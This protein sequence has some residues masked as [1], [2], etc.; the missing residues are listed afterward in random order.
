MG[1]LDHEANLMCLGRAVAQTSAP[2]VHSTKESL[3][4]PCSVS[5]L[6]ITSK[7]PSCQEQI[8]NSQNR[9]GGMGKKKYGCIATGTAA[10]FPLRFDVVVF[11][12]L[13]QE[14]GKE[15]G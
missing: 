2:L 15:S 9:V 7:T 1:D 12:G 8:D 14:G 4:L 6:A 11:G 13:W 10:E 5:L 3:S